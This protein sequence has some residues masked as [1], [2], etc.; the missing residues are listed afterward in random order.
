MKLMS[1]S[2]AA[3]MSVSLAACG[4]GG[5]ESEGGSDSD[6][7]ITYWNIGTEGADKAALEYAVNAFNE[8]TDSGYQVEM[9]AIQN[10]NYKE[11]LVVAMSSGECPDMYTSWSG[12]PMNEYID[13]G[14]AQ[15]VDD[16]YE[17]YGLN[18]IFMEA[19]TAQAS[20]NGHIYA[21][22]TYNVSLAGIFYNTEIFD[23]YNL[24]VPTTLSELEAVC[25][26]LVENGITPFALANGPKWTGS[27]YFQCLVARYAGLEPFQAAVDGSGSF[28]DECFRWA[29]EKIQEWV[30]KGYFP[31]G[32]NSLDEDAGQ[33][34][35]LI[36]QESAAM[37]LTGSWYT[38]T[39]S[40]D[41]PEFYEK[42]DWFSFPAVDGSDADTSIQ[43]GTIGD[44]FVSF[45]CEGEKLDVAFE[46]ASYYASDEAQQVMVENGKIPPTKDAESLVTDPISK[47]VLEAANNASSTQLWWDQYL[48]PE[49]AQVHLD[50]C[51]ELFG[52]TMT[53]EEADAQ[54]QAAME[55]YN[56][57]K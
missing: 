23:E 55:E 29:G 3:V 36:Y 30:Q 27:M 47:K 57:D 4:S 7:T 11:R 40:T 5:G 15:P 31:E 44:Q 12:G 52:L 26:T 46:C 35:Q 1:L 18:D 53:P 24:E 50:T 14:F 32:V 20:Y 42:M 34:K 43:I 17:E 51:Q 13:S 39:F 33:A 41:S 49:V 9:V 56:A 45:N 22:P 6:K 21:V 25:D 10:D 2:L 16:L 48:A 28:E 8:N 54:L 19:A 37:M 38:G